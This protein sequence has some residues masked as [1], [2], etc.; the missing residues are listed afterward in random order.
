[1]AAPAQAQNLDRFY[2]AVNVLATTACNN[3]FNGNTGKVN[4]SLGLT[5]MA[6]SDLEW[7]DDYN[8]LSPDQKREVEKM[9]IRT[10]ANTCGTYSISTIYALKLAPLAREMGYQI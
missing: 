4:A 3:A 2:P 5:A 7:S 6:Y 9:I 10:L 8:K 1:M